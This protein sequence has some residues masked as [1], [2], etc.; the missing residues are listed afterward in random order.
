MSRGPINY[1]AK[2]APYKKSID[3]FES[4][5]KRL[6]NVKNLRKDFTDP[7]LKSY[8]NKLPKVNKAVM[9]TG[10]MLHKKKSKKPVKPG[11]MYNRFQAKKKK[12]GKKHKYAYPGDED[13]FNKQVANSGKTTTQQSVPGYRDTVKGGRVYDVDEKDFNNFRLMKPHLLG[14]YLKSVSNPDGTANKEKWNNSPDNLGR[15]FFVNRADGSKRT[16][17]DGEN[18]SDDDMKNFPSAKEVK[19]KKKHKVAHKV[20]QRNK[21]RARQSIPGFIGKMSKSALKPGSIQKRI[22]AMNLK[23]NPFFPFGRRK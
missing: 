10:M 15:E 16:E 3:S 19:N 23:K 13:Y 6:I 20:P 7:D 14:K 21:A 18:I 4:G 2:G 9:R 12:M 22:K 17:W 5:V 1:G 8:G 11:E